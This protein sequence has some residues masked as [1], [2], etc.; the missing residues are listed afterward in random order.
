MTVR[1]R[2]FHRKVPDKA[3]LVLKMSII[4]LDKLR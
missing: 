3:I 4:G 1:S 2:L